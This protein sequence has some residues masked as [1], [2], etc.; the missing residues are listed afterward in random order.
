MFVEKRTVQHPFFSLCIPQYNRTSFLLELCR[1]VAAQTFRDVELCISDG[2]ST[3]NRQAE[4]IAFLESQGLS[5]VYQRQEKTARYDQNLR[6]AISLARGQ[7]CL[8]MGNDDALA[9]PD[10]LALLVRDMEQFGP[11]GVVIPDF[12]DFVTGERAFRIRHSRNL[13]AGPGVAAG[14]FRNFSFVSGVVLE[15]ETAQA[16]AT[17][18]WDSSEMYQT[19][20]GCRLIA[21][22]LPLLELERVLV[23]KDIQIPGERVDSY[24]AKPRLRDCPIVERRLPLGMLGRVVTDAILPY[25][26]GPSR[27]SV[28]T[29][30]LF[31]ILLFTYPFWILEYRRV[32][33]WRYALGICLGMRPR[34]LCEGVELCASR[35]MS[36][37]TIYGAVTLAG[38]VTPLGLFRKVQAQLYRLAKSLF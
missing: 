21:S 35:Q 38:L 9:G 25:L 13:G 7:Y 1:S 10:S 8:L 27:Q 3:D 34:I 18:K 2:G 26:V 23:R 20:V 37:T 17:D 14:H 5:F 4:I 19:Y 31:Q 32:Q 15:R 11:A 16:V 24:A 29:R 6:A 12:E 33:S 30:V 36:L 22:G 28:P